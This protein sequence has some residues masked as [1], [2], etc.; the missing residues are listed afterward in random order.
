[1]NDNRIEIICRNNG[2]RISAPRGVTLLELSL[3]LRIKL[4]GPVIAAR[5]NNQPKPLSE[6]L[7]RN[8]TIEYMD[9]TCAEGQ[10]VYLRSVTMIMYKAMTD[11]FPGGKVRVEHSIGN[12]YFLHISLDG[13]PLSAARSVK[14]IA[15]MNELIAADLP[16][17]LH[18]EPRQEA[19]RMFEERGDTNVANLLRNQ[20][21]YY[22]YYY[23]LDGLPDFYL[24][25][26]A[27]GT[28]DVALFA[29]DPYRDGFLLRIPDRKDP[30]RLPDIVDA[31]KVFSTFEEHVKWSGIVGIHDVADISKADNRSIGLLVKV[32]EA[33]HEQKIAKIAQEIVGRG[34]V[35]AVLIARPSSSGKTTFRKRLCIQLG[36][37]GVI[38]RMLS[39]DDYF[40][41]RDQTP[42]D[43]FGQTDFESLYALDL[44]L[45]H[46]QLADLTAGKEVTTPTYNFETGEREYRNAPIRLGENEILVIEGIHG[47]NPELTSSIPAENKFLVYAS[48]LTTLSINDHNRIPTTDTRLLR[49]IIRD[50]KYR[51]YPAEKTIL[52][53]PSVRRGEEKWIFPYQE[54]ADAVFNTALI[55]E[56]YSIKRQAE[57]ALNEVPHDSDAYPEA[58]RLLGMLQFFRDI[59]DRLIPP[60]SL[61]REF[62]GGSDFHY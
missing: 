41:N 19:M 12:G 34:K 5:V 50:S 59:P 23:D 21:S 31:S 60:G 8:S 61:I 15:R 53:W 44:D 49:R 40:V 7:Y 46:Q 24:G 10:R 58:A 43:E 42:L 28:G 2:E 26:L 16:F 17:T 33:L 13:K 39:L 48:A 45:F 52:R 51:A 14:L 37:S 1:M 56:T 47:L 54:N 18:Y 22:T 27:R 6:A 9:V 55:T 4:T 36:A 3:L 29:L 35:R 57:V 30:S 62:I 25:V 11:L 32:T 38:P 20:K